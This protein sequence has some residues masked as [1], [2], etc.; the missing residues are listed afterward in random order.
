MIPLSLKRYEMVTLGRK[1]GE[2]M[3][4]LV[5]HHKFFKRTESFDY[6]GSC[7]ISPDE[8]KVWIDIEDKRYL[9][10]IDSTKCPMWGLG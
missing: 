10:L 4:H 3:K 1:E 6:Q 7:R 5:Y 8:P 9:L 2:I